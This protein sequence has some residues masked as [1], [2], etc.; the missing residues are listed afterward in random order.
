MTATPTLVVEFCGEEHPL[1][2]ATPFG[3]GRAADLIVDDDNAYL[4]RRLIEF[5]FDGDFWWIANVGSRLGVTLSG[6]SGSLVSWL[7]PGSRAPV[8]MPELAVMF[9]AGGTTYELG[10]S[11]SLAMFVPRHDQGLDQGGGDSTLG[12][13]KLTPMQ[14]RLILALA[15]P[16]LRRAGSG[17]SA[18]PSNAAAAQRLGWKPT[19]FNRKLDNVCEKFT[20]AGVQGLRGEPGKLAT[21]RRARLV[22][23]ATAARIVR[24]EHL[25]LLD[26]PEEEQGDRA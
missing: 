9:S 2:P 4:H 26:Q 11:A 16:T 13:V 1:D 3:V 22:E 24:S 18:I 19:T 5:S 14:F 7:G 15:E 23:Y 8:V 12:A 21:S 10:V 25:V 6:D 20:R 17:S